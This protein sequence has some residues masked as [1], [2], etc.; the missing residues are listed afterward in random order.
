M[1]KKP[2]VLALFLFARCASMPDGTYELDRR[3]GMTPPGAG[4]PELVVDSMRTERTLGR[5]AS[6]P[7]R[8]EP[9]IEKVWVYDQILEGGHWLQG[10]W[11]FVEIE[12]SK[13]LPEVDTGYAPLIKEES[14]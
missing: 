8:V 6:M 2:L 13:W 9:L 3:S 12:K 10:T 5:A 4:S 11:M 14:R 1:S 7:A